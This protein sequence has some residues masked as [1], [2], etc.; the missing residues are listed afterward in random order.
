MQELGQMGKDCEPLR[1]DIIDPLRGL[2]ALAVAWFHFTNCTSLLPQDSWVRASG[3]FGWLGV[4]LFFVISGF[5]IPYSMYRGGYCFPGDFGTFLVKRVVRLD[6]PYLAV[7]GVTL[8]LLW[9]SAFTP[10]VAVPRREVSGPQVLRDLG[11]LNAFLG[12]PWLN[13]VFWT[14]A[15]EFQFYVLVAVAFPVFASRSGP[16]RLLGV[17]LLSG[18]AFVVSQEAFVFRYGGLF[19]LGI[20]TFQKHAG[21]LSLRVYLVLVAAVTAATAYS[22]NPV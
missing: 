14:L 2:A 3:S 17:A 20:I 15:I 21:L 9:A 12:Y 10:G 6:P 19:A 1:V 11:Y 13:P 18:L 8:G 7:I 22:L 5:I 16:V 4:E